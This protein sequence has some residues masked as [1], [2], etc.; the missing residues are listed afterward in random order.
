[1]TTFNWQ[2][3]ALDCYPEKDGNTNVVF[4]VHW[5]CEGQH[6][7]FAASSYSTCSLPAPGDSFV[8]YDDLTK[9]DVLAWIWA[10][11][12]DKDTVE[13][14]VQRQL[15]AQINPPVVSPRLPWAPVPVVDPVPTE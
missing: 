13:E 14:S 10:N 9:E 1:M 4:T 11:G 5:R 3:A 2:I 15:D 7:N 8:A 12:V 6:E